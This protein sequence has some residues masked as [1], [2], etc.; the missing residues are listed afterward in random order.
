MTTSGG[1]T[2]LLHTVALVNGPGGGSLV[3][4]PHGGDRLVYHGRAWRA[5]ART[6]RIDPLVWDDSATPP[7]VKV[8]GPTVDPQERP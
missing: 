6:P 8:R 1:A 4:G 3:D 5:A 2:P 7:T